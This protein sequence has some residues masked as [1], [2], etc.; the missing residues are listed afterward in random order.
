MP[1]QERS[2][3]RG[4]ADRK[5]IAISWAGS[6]ERLESGEGVPLGTDPLSRL[7]V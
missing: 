6:F 5:G 3:K 7:K 1:R 2:P 4:G